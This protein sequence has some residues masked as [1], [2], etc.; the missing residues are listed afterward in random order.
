MVSGN[1]AKFLGIKSTRLFLIF[2]ICLVFATI[3]LISISSNQHVP[4]EDASS[5]ILLAKGNTPDVKP[6]VDAWFTNSLAKEKPLV[7]PNKSL[8]QAPVSKVQAPPPPKLHA[9]TYAS[10]GGR[11]DR[12]C[13]AVHSAIMYN[14]DLIILGWGVKWTGLAQKLEA[15]YAFSKSLPP[16]DIIMFTDAFDVLFQNDPATIQQ[17]F[18]DLNSTLVFSAECG[19]WPHIMENKDICLKKYPSSPTPYRYLNSGSWI[20]EA[21]AAAEMLAAIM[22]ESGNDFTNAND[23]KL[24]GDMFI[25]GRFGIKL[26]YYN[27]IF[28]SMHMT[29]DPPLPRCDPHQDMQLSK[30]SAWVNKRTQ[31]QPAVLHFNGGGK[32]YH[33]EME[34]ALW[35]KEDQY[36][37]PEELMKLREHMV[38]VPTQPNGKMKFG[39]LCGSY[40]DSL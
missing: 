6:N 30:G 38:S 4:K 31:S 17:A 35:Y 8:A 1:N 3:A 25:N 27:K 2:V 37:T 36:S 24:V 20:G 12:F 23:Q 5:D 15:A 9:V 28:Q 11:D 29:L 39:E 18:H 32:R 7:P 16:R 26:D 22:K 34:G 10:H 19:C 40:I 33:L 14:Y 21:A 13:R